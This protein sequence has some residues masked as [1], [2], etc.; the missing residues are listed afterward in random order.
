[1]S[2]SVTIVGTDICETC[3]ER[4]DDCDQ[5]RCEICRA[6]ICDRRSDAH[7]CSGACSA[8]KSRRRRGVRYVAKHVHSGAASRPKRAPDMRISYSKALE[9]LAAAAPMPIRLMPGARAW[10]RRILEPLLTDRQRAHL[11]RKDLT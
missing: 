8:E 11:G 7:V 9:A 1:M 10:A 6:P 3:A 2:S 4:L 5:R